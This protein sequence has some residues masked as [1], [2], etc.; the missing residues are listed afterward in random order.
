M[1]ISIFSRHMSTQLV[2]PLPGK[3]S[4][5]QDFAN[6]EST[7]HYCII[8]IHS[9][10][11]KQG[12]FLERLMLSRLQSHF[13]SLQFFKSQ[14]S[15][16]TLFHSSSIYRNETYSN[17]FQG[18]ESHLLAF[19]LK[20]LR[21]L[22]IPPY[23]F[24]S[25]WCPSRFCSWPYVVS[26]IHKWYSQYTSHWAELILWWHRTPVQRAVAYKMESLP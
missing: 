18:N 22:Q 3:T 5:S 4:K 24:I 10:S 19:Y 14:K 17:C 7:H 8:S 13:E 2:L 20:I 21:K 9:A 12:N 25:V 26:D 11:Y 1:Q 15:N 6:Q 16:W 23:Y